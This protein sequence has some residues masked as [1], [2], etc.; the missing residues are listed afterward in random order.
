MR[1]VNPFTQTV[2]NTFL[3]SETLNSN[4]AK[5]LEAL[6]ALFYILQIDTEKSKPKDFCYIESGSEWVKYS[7]YSHI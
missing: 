3:S 1:Q 2:K 4:S 5:P 7:S 6:V